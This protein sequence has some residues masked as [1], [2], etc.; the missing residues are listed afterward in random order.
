[1]KLIRFSELHNVKKQSPILANQKLSEL[2][3]CDLLSNDALYFVV[4][5]DVRWVDA[6]LSVRLDHYASLY[7]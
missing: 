4:S 1:M 6:A 5:L 2:T 3:M 7:F